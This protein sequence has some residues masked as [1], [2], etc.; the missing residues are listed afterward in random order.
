MILIYRFGQCI[1]QL[2]MIGLW[3][4]IDSSDD[5]LSY[6]FARLHG[7]LLMRTILPV[8]RRVLIWLIYTYVVFSHIFSPLEFREP[9]PGSILLVFF[10]SWATGTSTRCASVLNSAIKL[11]WKVLK[12]RSKHG[13]IPKHPPWWSIWPP[14]AGLRFFWLI[15]NKGNLKKCMQ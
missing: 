15:L 12:Q 14:K 7:H 10:Y 11:W 4:L 3:P 8:W 2:Q 13:G 5:G 6:H 1:K 9:N